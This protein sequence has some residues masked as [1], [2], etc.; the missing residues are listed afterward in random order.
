[1]PAPGWPVSTL[2]SGRFVRRNEPV[3]SEA[4][5]SNAASPQ[6]VPVVHYAPERNIPPVSRGQLEQSLRWSLSGLP[7]RV[8]SLSGGE[9]VIHLS[10][11]RK[12]RI[13]ASIEDGEDTAHLNILVHEI[14][15]ADVPE[16]MAIHAN[17]VENTLFVA[18]I[19]WARQKAAV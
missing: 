10:S 8:D 11:G 19:M 16:M 17:I 5:M 14:E 9:S 6:D 7:H 12:V 3:T 4:T 13:T 18:Q 2:S 1:M 15:E